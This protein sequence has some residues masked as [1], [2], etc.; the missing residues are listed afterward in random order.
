MRFWKQLRALLLAAVLVV[1]AV[2]LVGCGGDDNSSS[3]NASNTPN[4]SNWAVSMRPTCISGGMEMRTCTQD[5]ATNTEQR[6]I[7]KFVCGPT[8]KGG[9][10]EAVSIGGKTWMKKNLYV[11]VYD[12]WCYNNN[13]DSCNKYG[14]LY[15]WSAA[16]SACQSIGWR[17]PS[18]QDWADLVW[19]A[20]NVGNT[21]GEKLKST[22]G[23]K[24]SRYGRP[25]TDDYG[26][27]ALPGGERSAD[28]IFNDAGEFGGW[29]TST[30]GT[31]SNAYIRSMTSDYND[32]DEWTEDRNVGMSVRCV[33]D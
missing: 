33:A 20:G 19:A 10:Y 23:W 21:A 30:E 16:K 25:G 26:F 22:T 12:S 13:A 31:G 5:N 8:D 2:C 11:T 7:P 24:S 29:W 15:T 6:T 17:L 4:C 32:V 3:G 9:S 27:S 14:R 18:R 1:G 28:G